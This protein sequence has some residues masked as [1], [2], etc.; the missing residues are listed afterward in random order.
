MKPLAALAALCVLA[1]CGGTASPSNGRPTVTLLAQNL[2]LFDG[3]QNA[4]RIGFETGSDSTDIKADL[5]PD[6]AQLA[7]C[8]LT[9]V[10]ADL[11]PIAL[12]KDIGSGVRETIASSGLRAVALVLTGP[13][14]ARANVLLEYDDGGHQAHVVIP[15]LAAPA[16]GASC[17]DNGCN[18]FF[19]VRPVHNGSFSATAAWK[20]PQATLEML[21]GSVLGRSQTATGV[22][23]RVAARAEGTS[24]LQI[25]TQLSGGG[26]YALAITQPPGPAQA[27]LGGVRIDASWP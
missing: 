20:G 27:P 4:L 17:A 22:P 8:P 7:V 2:S 15:F 9:D 19:E 18:P 1:A 25:G 14:S 23:Y 26:E 6:T 10:T 5:T 13:S 24:P 3:E 21:Q 12:C 11:P 16:G